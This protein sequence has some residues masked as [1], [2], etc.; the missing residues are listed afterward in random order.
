MSRDVEGFFALRSKSGAG[1]MLA[2]WCTGCQTES[3]F[4]EDALK[5]GARISHC[6]RT[7]VFSGTAWARFTLPVR[8]FFPAG[9]RSPITVLRSAIDTEVP[10]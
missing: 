6:G 3:V 8:D 10:Q 4:R 1:Q 7:E 5:R 2:H 9:E